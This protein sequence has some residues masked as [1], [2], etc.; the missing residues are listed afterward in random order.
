MNF[1]RNI[2]PASG[3]VKRLYLFK[4]GDQCKDVTGGW[5]NYV[6]GNGGI[7]TADIR[8]NSLYV[9]GTGNGKKGWKPINDLTPEMLKQYD[10][11]FFEYKGAGYT[12]ANGGYCEFYAE[13]NSAISSIRDSNL[14]NRYVKR[15]LAVPLKTTAFRFG[16]Q[17]NGNSTSYMWVSKVWL[18]KVGE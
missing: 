6:E 4:D 2:L 5:T 1:C 10:Y 16:I 12:D 8:E 15:V 18:E 9:G 7:Y 13:P 3:G 11:I 17:M 14:L